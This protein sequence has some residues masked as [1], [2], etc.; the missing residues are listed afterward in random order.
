MSVLFQI[1]TC[2]ASR[3]ADSLQKLPHRDYV[4]S[5]RHEDTQDELHF[6]RVEAL[7]VT[8]YR[9]CTTAMISS[10]DRVTDLG[11]TPWLVEVHQQLQQ[12]KEPVEG[13]RHIMLYL[14]DGPCY[15]FICHDFS[16]KTNKVA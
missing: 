4:L 12:A 9:A 16:A 7:R 1:S 3:S 11:Q 15:E 2:S 8:H 5:I 10:Y 6:R 14:D 13:L